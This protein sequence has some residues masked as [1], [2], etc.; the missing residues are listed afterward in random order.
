MENDTGSITPFV[1]GVLPKEEYSDVNELTRDIASVLRIDRDRIVVDLIAVESLKGEKGDEGP[2]GLQG[3]TGPKGDKG[4]TGTA[5]GAGLTPFVQLVTNPTTIT[6]DWAMTGGIAHQNAK[7]TLIAGTGAQTLVISGAVTGM[8]GTL[9]LT[10][11]AA[12]NGVFGLPPGS[13]KSDPIFAI[14]TTAGAVD[15]LHW[16]YDGTNYFWTIDNNFISF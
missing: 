15:V 7:L 8:H 16:I 2:R 13:M 5:G 6:A 1:T 12:G 11:N 10:Q 14:S 4:E 3:E 9:V